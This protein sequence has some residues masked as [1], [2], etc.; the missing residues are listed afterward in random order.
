MAWP[1]REF[2]AGRNLRRSP[3][4]DRLA[5][6]GACFGQKAGIERPLWFARNGVKPVLE[7][8]FGRQ[9]WFGCHAA[10]HRAAREAVALFDQSSFSKLTFKGRDAVN[11]LQ[12]LCGN[13]VDV[14]IG[15]V[16]YTGLFNERGTFE[17]DLTVVRLAEDEYYIV[18]STSQGI[19]DADWIR[20]HILT[21]EHAELV[22]VT[23]SYSVLGVMGPNAQS[24]WRR[25]L[26][27]TCRMRHFPLERHKR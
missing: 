18:T 2:E 9:N 4:H 23:A 19:H 26:K 1:N 12:R 17:S 20:R 10:E 13:D 25:S 6:Q 27:P 15:K 24:C 5:A 3:L 14:P 11:V 21:D 16:V 22:D 7:Y 8:A